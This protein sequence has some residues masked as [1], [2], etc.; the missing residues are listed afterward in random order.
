MNVGAAGVLCDQSFPTLA[1]GAAVELLPVCIVV[2]GE[3][4]RVAE[5]ELA[6][7]QLLARAQ[8]QPGEI[9]VFEVEQIEQVQPDLDAAGARLLRVADAEASL[10][11]R[12]AGVSAFEGDDLAVH[13]KVFG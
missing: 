9:V 11:S 13:N 12:E 4:Q 3:A 10:Q 8:R 2:G 6:A 1:A 7:Q 5:I